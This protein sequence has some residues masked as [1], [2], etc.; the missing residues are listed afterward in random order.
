MDGQ[1]GLTNNKYEGVENITIHNNLIVDSKS[2]I[3][4]GAAKGFNDPPRNITFTKNRIHRSDSTSENLFTIEN[5]TNFTTVSDNEIYTKGSSYGNLSLL[6]S[7]YIIN[8]KIDLTPPSP[9]SVLRSDVGPSFHSG[10]ANSFDLK[11]LTTGNTIPYNGIGAGR[12]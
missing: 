2:S 12:K 1:Y 7:G 10:P 4:F 9:R 6:K 11:N 5:D 3:N 8:P